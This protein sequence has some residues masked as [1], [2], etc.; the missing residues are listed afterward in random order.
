[1]SNHTQRILAFL[2]EMGPR[3]HALLTRLT[4]RP[5]AAEDLMQELFLK[6][7]RSRH[8][9][10]A[11]DPA[12]Y[13]TQTA[14]HLAFDWRRHQKRQ[15]HPEML[16]P[17]QAAGAFS[18]LAAL[19]Q[20]EEIEQVLGAMASLSPEDRDLLVLRYL[21]QE[22]YEAIAA[23]FGKTPHQ[24]RALC[25]KALVRLRTLLGIAPTPVTTEKMNHG[26]P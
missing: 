8:W 6:L 3:L 22:P 7:S 19:V 20:R 5:E 1:L 4:L 2:E 23:Q 10:A 21:Q 16:G 13:A 24:V 11:H 26:N 25:H 14:I 12:A 17:E 18:P 9:L 15:P